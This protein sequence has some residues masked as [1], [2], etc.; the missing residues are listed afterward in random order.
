MAFDFTYSIPS[1]F[2]VRIVQFLQQMNAKGLVDAFRRC[3][4]EYEDVGL[5]Y[6][7]GLHGDNWNKNAI[8]INIEGK[9]EDL[10]LLEGNLQILESVIG[11]ALKSNESGLLLRNIFFLEEVGNC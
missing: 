9:K 6:Y 4:Y 10:S 1:N 5:A 3:K 8:D 11:K 7:A 2:D